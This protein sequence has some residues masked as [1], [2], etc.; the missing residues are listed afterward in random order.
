ML[1]P[2]RVHKC[3]AWRAGFLGTTG[4]FTL[5]DVKKPERLQKLAIGRRTACG[6]GMSDG[7]RGY[8]QEPD[9]PMRWRSYEVR[10][11][12]A[13]REI[14]HF[15]RSDLQQAVTFRFWH[16]GP[17][18]TNLAKA[19]RDLAGSLS[20]PS[21]RR[22]DGFVAPLS[23]ALAV[24][25]GSPSK[26]PRHG[27]YPVAVSQRGA[28]HVRERGPTRNTTRSA[29]RTASVQ[30]LCGIHRTCLEDEIHVLFDCEYPLLRVIQLRDQFFGGLLGDGFRIDLPH[31][32]RFSP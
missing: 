25:H 28:P 22:G 10:S 17:V 24:Q 19:C 11:P 2:R 13:L 18:A 9:V 6:V 29:T 1:G 14:M 3:Q 8:E 16:K 26:G 5:L 27:H 32:L 20:A 12:S 7:K 15:L 31:L 4:V 30:V 23:P 21:T